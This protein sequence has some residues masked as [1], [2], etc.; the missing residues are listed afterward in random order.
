M[1]GLPIEAVHTDEYAATLLSVTAC[2]TRRQCMTA[3][4]AM[5]GAGQT[6][7]GVIACLGL[8]PHSTRRARS[9]NS[10]RAT[11]DWLVEGAPEC[12]GEGSR[13]HDEPLADRR[14][15]AQAKLKPEIVAYHEADDRGQQ[16][17]PVMSNL[18]L[19]ISSSLI[20]EQCLC[21]EFALYKQ[22]Q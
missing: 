19:F 12:P 20:T 5:W 10:P 3:S 21:N 2:P 1:G 4:M 14:D 9:G 17:M 7:E 18:D 11:H 6:Q 15:T 22:I 8:S 16:S 13:R